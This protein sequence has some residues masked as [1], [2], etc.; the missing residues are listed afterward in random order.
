VLFHRVV[1]VALLLKK[2]RGI[3]IGA[4]DLRLVNESRENA[5][6]FDMLARIRGR[7][8]RLEVLTQLEV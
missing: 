5:G 7:C 2:Q 3:G 8:S 1:D 4:S 6:A